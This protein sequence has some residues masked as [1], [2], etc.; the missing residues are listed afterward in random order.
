MR[1]RWI[2]GL[3]DAGEYDR[4]NIVELIYYFGLDREGLTPG[5]SIIEHWAN[6]HNMSIFTHYN[7]EILLSGDS[8][9]IRAYYSIENEAAHTAQVQARFDEYVAI[10]GMPDTSWMITAHHR[11]QI[12]PT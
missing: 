3:V 5:M 11:P 1:T 4:V 10:H 7:L 6:E 9:L 8:E 12:E 2:E